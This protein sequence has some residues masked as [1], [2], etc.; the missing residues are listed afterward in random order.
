MQL[1]TILA[2]IALSVNVFKYQKLN[3]PANLGEIRGKL[4]CGSAQPS[5][6]LIMLSGT[7]RDWPD[8]SLALIK[9]ATWSR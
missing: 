2:K 1:I 7:L 4:E 8:T 9:I 3:N 5:L 6:F